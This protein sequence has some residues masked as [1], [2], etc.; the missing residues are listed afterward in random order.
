[1]CVCL[2]GCVFMFMHLCVCVYVCVC[3]CLFICVCV[4]VCTCGR[5]RVHVC[6]NVCLL[7]E[8]NQTSPMH[9]FR[10]C[11]PIKDKASQLAFTY[12]S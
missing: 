4:Y 5:A 12:I 8:N 9:K 2:S 3:L 6:V 10:L 11:V 7:Y 1:M